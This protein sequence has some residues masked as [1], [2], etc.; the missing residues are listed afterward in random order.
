LE[1]LALVV[2]FRSNYCGTILQ[3]DTG[4]KSN[5]SVLRE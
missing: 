5:L 4:E 2:F 1:E 3:M